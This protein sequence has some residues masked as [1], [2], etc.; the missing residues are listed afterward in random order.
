[1]ENYNI[2]GYNYNHAAFLH[3]GN[4]RRRRKHLKTCGL[5]LQR[6]DGL[7]VCGNDYRCFGVPELSPHLILAS[8]YD[9][10]RYFLECVE[11]NKCA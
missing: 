7:V 4:R 5:S 11:T 10:L 3:N 8:W 1:M 2:C 6:G 9:E